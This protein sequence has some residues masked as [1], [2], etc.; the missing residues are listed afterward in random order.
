MLAQLCVSDFP[1]FFR[2]IRTVSTITDSIATLC[3]DH[4]QI[5]G[6]KRVPASRGAAPTLLRDMLPPAVLKTKKRENSARSFPK[7]NAAI[8]L[9]FP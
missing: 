2:H 3:E 4:F 8:P 6:A 1:S 7:V 5:V 9:P